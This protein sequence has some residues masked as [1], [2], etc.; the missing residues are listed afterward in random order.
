MK[1]IAIVL[2]AASLGYLHQQ[3]VMRSSAQQHSRANAQVIR[4]TASTFE[5]KPG[6]ITVK[7]GVPVILELVS[8]DRHHGFRLSEFHVRT[9]VEPGTIETVRFVPGKV[10]KFN[11]HCDVFCGG[12]HEEMSGTIT[13]VD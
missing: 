6:E 10:G 12:G 2:V 7:K 4:I 8:Q 11:F 3:G 13:V 1:K 5:F 9:D